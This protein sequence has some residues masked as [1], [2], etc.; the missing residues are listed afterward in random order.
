MIHYILTTQEKTMFLCGLK[1][2]ILGGFI[3]TTPC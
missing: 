3:I 2:L 1:I